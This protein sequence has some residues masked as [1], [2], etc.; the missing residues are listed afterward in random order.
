MGERPS[1]E[2]PADPWREYRRRRAIF[3]FG[4]LGGVVGVSALH[5]LGAGVPLLLGAYLAVFLH[6]IV[7]SSWLQLFPCPGCGRAWLGVPEESRV[8]GVGILIALWVQKLCCHCGLPKH[9]PPV[10]ES[11]PPGGTA[12]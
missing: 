12:E 8:Y 7:A 1:P 11:T 5:W 9:T 3:W 6:L 4:T 2:P 10:E